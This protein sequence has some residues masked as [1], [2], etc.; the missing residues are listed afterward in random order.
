[1]K[2]TYYIRTKPVI[3]RSRNTPQAVITRKGVK[4]ATTLL[5]SAS[6]LLNSVPVL[7]AAD[8][9][10]N[11]EATPQTVEQVEP[12]A[13]QI[14]IETTPE[15]PGERMPIESGEPALPTPIIPENPGQSGEEST[16][17][18]QPVT[19]EQPIESPVTPEVPE[20]PGTPEIPEVPE[21]SE[22][23]KTPEPFEP[24][25]PKPSQPTTPDT[26]E[27]PSQPT[28]PANA[29][30]GQQ[31][32]QQSAGKTG[33]RSSGYSSQEQSNE[34]SQPV[35]PTTSPSISETETRGSDSLHFEKNE[36]VESFI[37]KIGES[38]RKIGQE[39][40]LY[41]SVMIAQAILESGSGSSELSQAP[42]HNLFG[43]KGT[44]E[45]SGV[46]YSTQEDTGN[47]VLVTIQASFRTYDTYDQS[48]EDYSKLFT[49]GLTGNANFYRGAWKSETTN[50][51]EATAFLTGRYATDTQYNKKLNG[52]IEAY[53]L[54]TYDQAKEV[55][56]VH[57]KGYILPVENYTI[58]SV[59]GPR[60][61]EFHRGLDFA[62][63]QGEPIYA[64]KTG[65]VL[66]AEYHDSWGNYVVLG[67]ED[68]VSTLYAHQAEYVVK[69][70]ETVEQ[71][72]IIGYV[73]S[74]GNSTGSHLHFEVCEDASL[75]QARLI[76]PEKVL[77]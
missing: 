75:S 27:K 17:P 67:H 72:Q 8:E 48:F 25:Q 62:A 59:Y 61:G 41:A 50:Y 37:R 29:G 7:A 73:G 77:F 68:G 66:T 36:S 51:K 23:P 60:G 14:P 47:G 9:G 15:V 5:G 76:N 33:G 28:K 24:E 2:K 44:Y 65:T 31:Q 3:Y 42:H 39:N 11:T 30:N 55:K 6:I 74:T 19:P 26:S 57:S 16:E 34:K 40:D 18:V 4:G 63:N 35:A 32:E 21:E 52:L 20:N 46:T 45:G 71:G 58:S 38:A 49:E 54:T 43:M 1:M 70:G 69:P 13:P 53:D 22:I 10:I 56:G 12:I 64:S